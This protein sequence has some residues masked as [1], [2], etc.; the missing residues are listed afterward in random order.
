VIEV[1]VRARLSVDQSR[2]ARLSPYF[3][4]A[5]LLAALA[6]L[7]YSAGSAT[8]VQDSWS[9]LV[10]GREITR[11][12]LPWVDHLTVFGSGHRWV[13]QQWLAQ[14]S[15][16]GVYG[17]GGLKALALAGAAA[18]LAA[19]GAVVALAARERSASPMVTMVL[20][21]LAVASAPWAF[22]VRAQELAMPLFAIV[23]GLLLTDAEGRRRRTVAV[24]PLL[25]VWANVHGS[26][27]LG[28]TLV[29][30]Y[31]L[32]LFRAGGLNRRTGWRAAPFVLG[33]PL[34]V[35]CSPYGLHLFGYYRL[36]LI[37]PPF[38]NL[39]QE[40]EPARLA[41][42]T[43]GFFA[44]AAV[45]IAVL[46]FRFRRFS[47]FEIALL[48]ITL[49]LALNALH[50]TV[51]FALAA[52]AVLPARVLRQNQASASRAGGVFAAAATAVFAAVCVTA[53]AAPASHYNE[54]GTAAARA[55]ANAV[56]RVPGRV[57]ADFTHA[58]WVLWHV[59]QARGR[60]LYDA[61]IELVSRANI[62][63]IARVEFLRG[64]YKHTLS[65]VNLIIVEPP[66]ARRLARAHWGRLLYTDPKTTI[67]L[68]EQPLRNP[69]RFTAVFAQASG[70]G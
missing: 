16:Y 33:P 7:L 65:G 13:D 18:A 35:F 51:W 28:A 54:L 5:V 40:W 14:L 32:T 44:L 26:V 57:Y 49:P 21:F 17:L 41:W 29:S 60:V 23:L 24:L 8:V 11:F 34:T 52:L 48:A 56:Q 43:A 66:L 36:L 64:D 55:A 53:L 3:P 10:G 67:L 22:Q 45:T 38:R 39:I 69:G 1:A 42:M 12:G 37:N 25:C 68:R 70:P 46:I 15:L 61:R 27:V 62:E 4:V 30:L 58:D 50:N 59:P 20:A 63:G 2:L 6:A 47:A 9:N 31:G 19:W